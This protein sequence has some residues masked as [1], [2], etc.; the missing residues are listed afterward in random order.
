MNVRSEQSRHDRLMAHPPFLRGGFRP[1]FLGGAIWALAVVALWVSA[2]ASRISLPTAFDP[3]AWH[4]H[5]MLF[6]YL[7]AVVSGFLMTAIPNWTGRFPVA[8]GRLA[9][10]AL[11]WLAARLAVLCS[12]RVGPAVAFGLDV[13]FLLVMA[14]FAAREIIVSRNRNFPIV[15]AL[16]LF[17]GANALDYAD[18]FGTVVSA[19]LGWRSGFAVVLMLVALIGG[20]II[21]S[22][23][24]NWLSKRGQTQGL[25]GQPGSFDVAVLAVSGAALA[26][27]A[28][29]PDSA[30]VA[31]L[32]LIAGGL[33]VV[34]LGRWSGLRT[35]ADPLVFIL[36]LSYAWL[37]LGLL[38]LGGSILAPAVPGTSALHALAAGAMGSM[39]LAVMT[40]AT[41]GHTGRALEADGWTV[42]IY[43]LVTGGTALRVAAPV[44]PFDYLGMLELAGLM[45]GGAFLLFVL[46]YGP[47]LIGPRP[48][49]RP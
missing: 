15:V 5:E 4:R 47:K 24:R 9:A 25:P 36:H 18:A 31:A 30:A 41:L 1:F 20:R 26:G 10:L 44:L 12:A 21:P 34:R 29:V 35:L 48:D 28:A 39:T 7:G 32:L 3:L 42:A 23:T 17:A 6:G 43:A 8:G 19:G 37:P 22:F 27:W 49:G 2:M 45:W 38:L 14:A 11:L 46:T 13:G 40:R 16:L 33:H